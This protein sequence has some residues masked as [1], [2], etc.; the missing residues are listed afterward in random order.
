VS[1]PRNHAL[2]VLRGLVIVL[3]TLDHVRG[4]IAPA[5]LSPE[6]LESTT[7]PFF[8]SRWVTHLCAPSFVLLMGAGV[9]LKRQHS[10][11]GLASYL[12]RRGLWIIL[13]ELSW[14]SFSFYWS[15][16]AS[17][18]GVL[19]ALGGSMIILAAC[20]RLPGRI[21]LLGG[22][23]L[24]VLLDGLRLSGDS[25]AGFGFVFAPHSFSVLGH[26]VYEAYALVPW[27]AVAAVGVGIGPWLVRA[28]PRQI[29]AAG[30]C[31][32]GLFG[33]IRVL[34]LGDPRGWGAQERGQLFTTMDFINPSKY[35][36]SLCYLLGTLGVALLI[37]AGPARGRGHLGRWLATLGQAPLFFYLLHLPV[38]HGLANAW[39]W[40][41]HGQGRV[42][43]EAPLS[44]GT[45]LGAW[46][47]VLIILWLPVRSWAR[48]KQ[49]RKDLKWLSYL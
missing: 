33:L 11:V 28:A 25:A 2:D 17:F 34:G 10:S 26:P 41:A 37:L 48:L 30:A 46:L 22:I 12:W 3:M 7:L 23:G 13:L 4:F 21:L 38:S 49:Q 45:I 27:F 6:H 29:A 39:A 5:G 24:T 32:V 47:L 15:L 8:L 20:V 31:S 9:G 18:L 14:V 44:M 35:P 42:P 40:W 16:Q 43:A 36:P 19:W 1:K